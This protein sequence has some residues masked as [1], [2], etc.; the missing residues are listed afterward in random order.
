MESEIIN[1]LNKKGYVYVPIK[2]KTDLDIIYAFFKKTKFQ[3]KQSAKSFIKQS[4][5]STNS[6][7][8][9]VYLYFGIFSEL[10]F[11]IENAIKFYLLAINLQNADA[12]V[13]LGKIYQ[14]QKN[15]SEMLKYYTL[16]DNLNHDGASVALCDYYGSFG[17]VKFVKKY[18]KSTGKTDSKGFFYVGTCYHQVKNYPK[19]EKYYTKAISLNEAKAMNNLA[20][21]YKDIGS[22]KNAKKYFKMAIDCDYIPA[23]HNLAGLYYKTAKSEKCLHYYLMA[24]EKN[25]TASMNSLGLYYFEKCQLD[26]AKKYFLMAFQNKNFSVMGFLNFI[27]EV[28]KDY[29]TAAELGC[30]LTKIN[31]SN[32]YLKSE[33]IGVHVSTCNAE[34]NICFNEKLLLI[35]PCGHQMCI[36]CLKVYLGKSNNTCPY[37]RQELYINPT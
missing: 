29:K 26:L 22:Y 17:D 4:I 31:F 20:F 8:D 30:H 35:L 1:F 25:Y 14:K 34:C 21:Y 7:S 6:H 24:V 11:N 18:L 37:C 10:S 16:A 13:N 15:F 19:M 33:N 32:L 3:K 23:I 27:I 12:M 9:I 5:D 36:D 28:E 2:N